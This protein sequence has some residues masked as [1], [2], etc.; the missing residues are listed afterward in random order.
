MFFIFQGVLSPIDEEEAERQTVLIGNKDVKVKMAIYKVFRLEK[1]AIKDV[2]FSYTLNCLIPEI[3][4]QTKREYDLPSD[5]TLKLN[6]FFL[7]TSSGP[8]HYI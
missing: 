1:Y 6:I 4:S 8:C 2:V 3:F 5:D 7:K